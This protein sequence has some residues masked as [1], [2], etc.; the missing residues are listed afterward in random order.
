MKDKRFP[1]ALERAPIKWILCL[2]AAALYAAFSTR[3]LS[4][5][6]MRYLLQIFLYIALGEAW[7]L[8]SGFAGMTSLG[9]QLYVGL[10]GFAVAVVTS[11]YE[12]PYG[13]GLA[14]GALVS[15]VVALL[16]S[17][18]LFRMWG[19]YFAIATWVAAEAAEKLFLNW[20][21][22]NQGGGMTVSIYPY[23]MVGQI[24]LMAFLL[25]LASIAAVY[26]LMRSRLGLGLIAMRD[27]AEAAA[28]IG[29]DLTRSRLIVYAFAALLTA[30]AGGVFFI[31]KGV[32]YPDSGFGVSW[33]VSVVF[34]CIIGGTG[35][36]AGPVAGAVLYVLLREF[37]A[38]Y[39][40][41]SNII[42]GLITI[43]VILYL[44]EGIVGAL[45]KRL[46]LSLFSME[47]RP[48]GRR[49]KER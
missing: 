41:W 42:L 30:L 18:V 37:L 23:P 3:V 25:C 48:D 17:R 2:A 22:V 35:T 32:I 8:L 6:A 27:D 43:V 7:N 38:H 28:S 10:G 31:N 21:F 47:R 39:P 4:T 9:Q 12:L 29:V 26:A 33:T 1:R 14:V 24:H 46:G 5:N 15:V 13:L 44:P 16:L 40:G 20:R 19:M 49:G 45:Q 34:V 11:T 36:V